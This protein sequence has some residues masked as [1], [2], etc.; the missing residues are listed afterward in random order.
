MSEKEDIE[1][2][3]GDLEREFLEIVGK[4]FVVKDVEELKKKSYFNLHDMG[5]ACIFCIISVIIGF[6]LIL[7]R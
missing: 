6:F 4:D 7:L 5:C 2:N 3:L 1:D